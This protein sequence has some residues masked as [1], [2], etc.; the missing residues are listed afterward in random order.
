MDRTLLEIFAAEQTEHVRQIRSLVDMLASQAPE[1]SNSVF[2]ELLRRAHTLKGAARAV[3]LEPTERLIHGL[4]SLFAKWRTRTA[5]PDAEGRAIVS[6]V[7][8]GVED[9]LGWA[10]GTRSEPAAGSLLAALDALLPEGSRVPAVPPA[11][12]G[13]QM[14][15]PSEP[16]TKPAPAAG[17]TTELVRV[18]TAVL[19][20]VVRSASQLMHATYADEGASRRIARHA[21]VVEQTLE[22]YSVLRRSCSPYIRHNAGNPEFRPVVEC[23][24]Y[25]DRQLRQVLTDARGAATAQEQYRRA[26]RLRVEEVHENACRA[27][28]TPAG[29]VFG[30]FGAMVRDVASQE[31]KQIDFRGEGLEI[32]ADREVLQALKDPIMHILR[33]AVSH[34]IETPDERIAQGKPENGLIRLRIESRGDHLLLAVEDDGRGLD[35]R[36]V[37]RQAVHQGLMTEAAVNAASPD[38][39]ARLIFHPGMTTCTAVTRLSG[40]GMG[41]SSVAQTVTSLRGEVHVRHHA[42]HGLTIALSVPMSISTQHVLLVKEGSQIFGLPA[43]FVEGLCRFR[44]ADVRVIDGAESIVVDQRPVP[45][46]RLA[47]LLEFAET[48]GNSETTEPAVHPIH[49][50]VVLVF[51][52]HRSAVVVEA[53]LDERETLIKDSGLPKELAGWSAGAIALED[54]SVAVMLSPGRLVQGF[55]PGGPSPRTSFQAEPAE[56]RKFRILVVDD[57]VTT[58]AMERSL[59]EAHGYEV[60]LA[61]DGVEAWSAIRDD[62]PDLVISDVSMPR[63]DGFQLL[64]RMK[65]EQSSARIP[66]ILVTSLESREEQERGLS[67]GADAYIVKRK[68]DQ[69]RPLFVSISGALSQRIRDWKWRVLPPAEKKPSTWWS[70]SHRT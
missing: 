17:T 54:G 3:G 10:L 47:D 43:A 31:S 63:M 24:E 45:L 58:R 39:L 29:T 27:R 13:K 28:M 6:R 5:A 8:D 11:A 2:D 49:Q 50:A 66:V 12:S 68:F 23:F 40:R 59:L 19:D 1:T 44:P 48:R 53:L 41:L 7:L 33:N 64:E 55:E 46:V 4:E 70:G 30:G 52:G 38:T 35:M 15:Q 34:G 65:S 61:V 36:A 60:R 26:L 32:Q 67:L 21:Q 69:I 51:G 57:S 16:E 62:P 20:E 9:I 22:E 18:N 42:G 25:L 37:S 14:P 56:E